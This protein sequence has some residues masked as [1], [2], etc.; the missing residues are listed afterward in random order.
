MKGG[1]ALSPAFAVM[2]G[3]PAQ[4]AGAVPG[5]GCFLFQYGE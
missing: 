2:F 5:E 4:A 1:M 3:A